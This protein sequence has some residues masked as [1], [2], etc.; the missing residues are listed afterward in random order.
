MILSFLIFLAQNEHAISMRDNNYDWRKIQENWLKDGKKGINSIFLKGRDFTEIYHMLGSMFITSVF[1]KCMTSK[2]D[3]TDS[4][5][6]WKRLGLRDVEQLAHSPTAF[7]EQI[8]TWASWSQSSPPSTRTS[9]QAIVIVRVCSTLNRH[10]SCE[11]LQIHGEPYTQVCKV[12][13]KKN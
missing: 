4:F 13:P 8:Q 5:H 7:E 9:V 11:A 1:S 12:N 2:A 6:R 10:G 3:V